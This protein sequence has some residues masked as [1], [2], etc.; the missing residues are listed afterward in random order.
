[1]T[2]RTVSVRLQAIVT[3]YM[4]K[5]AA[6]GRATDDF[7]HKVDI[8]KGRAAQGYHAIGVAGV[9]MGAVVAGGFAIAVKQAATFDAKMANTSALVRS[10]FAGMKDPPAALAAAMGQLRDAALHVGQQYGYTASQVA[11]AEAELAKAGLSVSD[12]INGALVGSLTLASAGQTDVATA[13]TIAAT[14]MVQ[15]GLKGRD[16]PHIAD[17]LAAG[18]DKALG[19]VT[20]LGFAL[21]QAGPQAHAFH[22]SLEETVGTLAAFAQAG[23]IGER[24]G[25]IFSQLL[26]KL[27]APGKQASDILKQ[28]G[29][30]IYGVNGQ[31]VGMAN[32][33]GQLQSKMSG[34]TE[35]QRNHDLAVIF[36]QRAIRGANILYQEGA[37]GIT[38]WTKKVNDSGFA[39]LQA[40]GKLDSLSGDVTKLKAALQTAFIG[41][42]ESGQGPLR[43]MTQ[44]VTKAVEVWTGLPGPVRNGAEAL[45][46]AGGAVT[47]AGGA[48]LLFIPKWT[49][50][51]AALAETRFGALS[52]RTALLG[53]GKVFGVV[54]VIAGVRRRRTRSTKR[55]A[56]PH[57]TSTNSPAA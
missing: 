22:V 16:V 5:F 26:L 12:M 35:A 40:S 15:F 25:T 48:A 57:R 13:T 1:M 55:S 47:F 50:M 41:A 20:D 3:D 6:A 52:A 43:S 7:A 32:L 54:T 44:D 49:A 10:S 29:I 23:Q 45:I 28:L 9:A 8:A 56:Q 24:G 46:L 2:D 19:S 33:A 39:A 14:A 38:D 17:L 53:V 34:L 27:V 37:Q 18:A 42:G 31:F 4:T 36:G 21:D 30:N 51:N 11:D